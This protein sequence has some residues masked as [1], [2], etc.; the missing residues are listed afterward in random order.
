M[1]VGSAAEAL[2]S[3]GRCSPRPSLTWVDRPLA[4]GARAVAQVSA[5]GRP[6]P[7]HAWTTDGTTATA[8]CRFDAPAAAGGPGPDGGALRRARSRRR[9]RRGHRRLTVAAARRPAARRRQRAARAARADRP[10]QRAVPRA[11]RARDPRRRVRPPRAWSCASSRRTTRRW[12][13]PTRRPR[14]WAPRPR[15]SSRR[16]ATA[17]PMMSLDNAFDEDE[18]RAW[19]ERL[20]RQAPELDLEAL[21]FSC[22]PKVDGVAMSLTYERGPVRPGG[23]PRRRR[24]RRGRDGERGHGEATCPRSW[25]RRAAP[26]PSVL[27]VRGEIYMPV[28][29]F[30]AM[31]KR[32]ADAGRAALRQPAQLGRRR[33]APEGP[34]R[35]GA[36]GRC[37]SGPTRSAIV[38]GAAGEEHVAGGHADGHPGAAGARPASRSAPTPASV[39]G[40]TAVVARCRELAELRHDLAY[41]ID[42]VV[43]KVDEL[44]LHQRARRHLAGAPLGHRLQVPAR[45]AHDQARSTSWSPSGAP[46]GPRPSP[47]SSRSSSAARPSAWRRCT[48]RTRWRPRT[49][50]RATS[51][52][53]ARRATSSPRSSARCARAPACPS[54]ASRSGSSR[55]RARPAASPSCACPARATPTAPTSTARRSG[56]SASRTTPRARPWTSRGWARS[57]CSS[58]SAPGSSTTPADLY[59]LTV[60]Q[61]VTLERFGALSAANLVAAIDASTA[62]P[63]SRLLVALGIRHVGPTVARA[64]ARAFGTLEA[65]EAATAE[66]LAAVD[67]VGGIIAASLAEFLSADTNVAVVRAAAAGRGDDGGAG[68]RRVRRAAEPGRRAP[69]RRRWPAR[70][71]WSPA[72]CPGYTREGAEEAIMARGG[73][74]PGSV[75]KK[76]FALGGRRRARR[77]QAQEGRRARHPDR[78]RGVASRRCSRRGELPG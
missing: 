11:R 20:R 47:A 9:R 69:R 70:R 75:S 18:L 64:V 19:A 2:R 45:G 48:T 63:L 40:M 14:P 5:H 60:E 56:C 24:H 57:A 7:V 10:Q 33:A 28:A 37:T 23:H 65:I 72:R 43:T 59:D 78:R 4:A 50:G 16:S 58:S 77:Q 51:S 25:P 46:G 44:A 66:E 39:E 38:E 30:E 55:R 62:Q 34:G 35:H 54:G 29:E 6:V 67:G 15:A 53:C 26:T 17:C 68:C 61:L 21:A 8:S 41:E 49:C 1:T 3:V 36:R 74:S 12:P 52:S 22:E 71:W 27:E 31:N 42:G 13:R 73:K 76:T 32:Q